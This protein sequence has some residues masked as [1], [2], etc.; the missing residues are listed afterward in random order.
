MTIEKLVRCSIEDNGDVFP[1][2]MNDKSHCGLTN[3]SGF[4]PSCYKDSGSACSGY[5]GVFKKSNLEYVICQEEKSV[6]LSYYLADPH[7]GMFTIAW[8]PDVDGDGNSNYGF[9]AIGSESGFG[10][11]TEESFDNISGKALVIPVVGSWEQSSFEAAVESLSKQLSDGL[12]QEEYQQIAYR[13]FNL[14]EPALKQA[15]AQ[16]IEEHLK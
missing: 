5:C 3:K 12:D 15:I 10:E 1:Y 6:G 11:I 4:T 8:V 9:L 7:D 13:V 2:N 14:I 16:A